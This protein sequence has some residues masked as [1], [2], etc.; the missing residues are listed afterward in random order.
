MWLCGSV[1]MQLRGYVAIC[2]CGYV[3]MWLCDCV[4][5]WRCGYVAKWLSGYVAM[6]PFVY[7]EWCAIPPLGGRRLMSPSYV[8]EVFAYIQAPFAAFVPFL[9]P[10][11]I[12]HTGST[13]SSAQGVAPDVKVEAGITLGGPTCIGSAGPI[14]WSNW[15]RTFVKMQKLKICLMKNGFMEVW[16]QGE[17]FTGSRGTSLIIRR[18]PD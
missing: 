15:G 18:R 5:M 11:R 4:A 17:G 12:C 9:V 6:W 3:A 2:L 1:A 14:K 10:S 7:S 13:N 8:P 16:M